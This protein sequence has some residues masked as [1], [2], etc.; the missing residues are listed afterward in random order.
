MNLLQ[1]QLSNFG[2]GGERGEAGRFGGEVPTH[3]VD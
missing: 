3:A 2:G 1:L